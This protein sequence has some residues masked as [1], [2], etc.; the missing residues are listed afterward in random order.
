MQIQTFEPN[1]FESERHYY[2]RAQNAQMHPLVSGFMRMSLERVM[3]RYCHLHPG[4]DPEALR[5][6]MTTEPRY[7][8]WSGS[9]IFNVSSEAGAKHKLIVETN[10]CP[11]GQKSFPLL[12]EEQ[13]EG[14][15]RRVLERTFLPSIK[16]S[17][18]KAGKGH[19]LAVLFDK[20]EME[21]SGYAQVLANLTGQSVHLIPV[22]YYDPERHITVRDRILYAKL[23]EGEVPVACAWRY[24][25]Q[26]PWTRLPFNLKTPILNPIVACLAGGR[27]KT[28]AAKAFELANGELR[29]TGLE[30]ESPE[31]YTNVHREEVPLLVAQLGGKAVVKIPYLNA[32]QGIHTIVSREELDQFM[33]SASDYEEFVVQ[34]LVGNVHWSS[35]SRRGKL[36]HIGTVPDSKGL[37]Y[38]FDLRMMVSWQESEYR[39]VAM[40]ARRAPQ[41]LERELGP[42]TSSWSVL[43]TNLSRKRSDDVWTTEPNRLLMMDRKDYAK[44]GLGIDDLIDA[45]IQAVLAHRAIDELAQQLVMRGGGLRRDLFA[46]LNNDAS[47]LNEIRVDAPT[48]SS[49]DELTRTQEVGDV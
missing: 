1:H 17:L 26:K 45:Y 27:N 43:G 29:G 9:D 14:G 11:S 41:P 30:I 5:R 33:E 28:T 8:R 39:P 19:C 3:L 25:T 20:N 49:G 44:L 38:A 46:S 34:Q 16:K 47:L 18:R 22:P 36:F 13:E 23:P 42:G 2:P 21:S 7:L 12:D 48:R 35:T 10:S 6:V 37:I 15:Y 40:Y 31:T 4:V 32:G 24:V